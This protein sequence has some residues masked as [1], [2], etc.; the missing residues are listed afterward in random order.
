MAAALLS[1]IEI[2]GEEYW[3]GMIT[4]YNIKTLLNKND[5]ILKR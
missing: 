5:K 4:K 1:E 2:C 3:R